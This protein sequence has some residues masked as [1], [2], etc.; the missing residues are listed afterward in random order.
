[1]S[2]TIRRK[3]KE[4]PKTYRKFIWHHCGDFP[5][6]GWGYIKLSG[7]ELK[8]ALRVFHSEKGWT[9][10]WSAPKYHRKQTS[11]TQRMRDKT[12]LIRFAKDRDY[13]PLVF[14]KMAMAYWT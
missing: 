14:D 2:R 3:N 13:E 9:F 12:E 4:Q 7:A 8:E 5:S 1:M 6:S 10:G 11:A